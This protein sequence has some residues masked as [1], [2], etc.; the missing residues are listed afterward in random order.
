MT[1]STA[2][3]AVTGESVTF[4]ITVRDGSLPVPGVTVSISN[5]LTIAP[6]L[7]PIT[8]AGGIARFTTTVPEGKSP[9][10]YTLSFSASKAG[11]AATAA[12]TAT[13]AVR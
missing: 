1:C 10:T 4:T 7:A 11:Y 5:G 13:I 2:T 3:T 9:G 8:D 12:K 6:F